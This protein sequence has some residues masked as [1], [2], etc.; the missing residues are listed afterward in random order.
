L[1][2]GN[3]TVNT[4]DPIFISVDSTFYYAQGTP[5]LDGFAGTDHGGSCWHKD[6]AGYVWPADTQWYTDQC[7]DDGTVNYDQI[8]G[9]YFA[10]YHN[11]DWGDDNESTSN[12]SQPGEQISP[13]GWINWNQSWEAFGEDSSFL[14]HL[15]DHQE[16]NSC[17]VPDSSAPFP[18]RRG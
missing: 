15:V 11:D 6:A 13:S 9:Y 12:Y 10:F 2:S 8:D 4:I 14:S 17:T 1:L 3:I 16:Y 7:D 5:V 18:R